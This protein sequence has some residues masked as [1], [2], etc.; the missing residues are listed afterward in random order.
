MYL[1]F[2]KRCI[3]FQLSGFFSIGEGT[4]GKK[5]AVEFEGFRSNLA[6]RLLLSDLG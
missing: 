6:A 4:G 1:Y 2:F 5:R 3:G